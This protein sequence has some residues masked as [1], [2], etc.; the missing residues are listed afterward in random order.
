[1]LTKIFEG[2]VNIL[3]KK[4]NFIEISQENGM[5]IN[6]LPAFLNIILQFMTFIYLRTLPMQIPFQLMTK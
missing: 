5:L 3:V 6:Y 2:T 1:M 4:Q